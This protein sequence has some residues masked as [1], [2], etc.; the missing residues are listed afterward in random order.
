MGCLCARVSGERPGVI[1]EKVG[2]KKE[3]KRAVPGIYV[4]AVLLLCTFPPF[5][6]FGKNC[7]TGCLP[8]PELPEVRV[9]VAGVGV[10]G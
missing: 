9:E 1:A 6:Y 4:I 5:K 3:R 7:A 2:E 10:G 8:I